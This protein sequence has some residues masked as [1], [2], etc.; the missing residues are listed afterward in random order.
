MIIRRCLLVL[1]LTLILFTSLLLLPAQAAPASPFTYTSPRDGAEVVMPQTTIAV[2][3]GEILAAS[4]LSPDRFHV[5]GSESGSH[6][7]EVRLARDERTAIFQPD[8][9]FA[10]GERV[11]VRVAGGLRTEAGTRLAGGEIAFTVAEELSP[12]GPPRTPQLETAPVMAPLR[13]PSRQRANRVADYLTVPDD[14]PRITVT[15]PASNTGEGYI[16]LTNYIGGI[17]GDTSPSRPYLLILDNSGEPVFYRRMTPGKSYWDFKKQP[18]GV[19]S[20][21]NEY[22][23]W[24]VMDSS[25]QII[26][27]ISAGNGYERADRHDFQLLDNGHALLILYDARP[28]DMSKV[29]PDGREDAW[30]I[31]LVIQ[32]LDQDD[33][34]VFQWRSWDY[35]DVISYTDSTVD[36]TAE[37]I[38]YMHTNAVEMDQDG[39]LLISSRFLDEITKINRNPDDNIVDGTIM[40]RFGGKKNQF[41]VLGDSEPFFDQHDIR[42][43]P[44]GNITLFDNHTGPGSTFSRGLEYRL[45]EESMIAEPV[46]EYR[47]DSVSWAMGNTQRLPNG[48]TLLGWG[49]RYP[50]LTEVTPA[51]EKAFELT[52]ASPATPGYAQVSYRAYRFPW[53]GDPPYPPLLLS[54]YAGGKI[55]LYTSWNGATGI[56]AYEIYGSNDV[57][58]WTLLRTEAKQGF[59]SQFELTGSDAGYCYYRV[60]PLD[61]AFGET[62]FSNLQ[63]AE[64]CVAS[65]TLLPWVGYRR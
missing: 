58:E 42:R 63:I 28:V 59:E 20:Y 21:G 39:N 55:T 18:S 30:V 13:P 49:L 62:Q 23:S 8:Q 14:Y 22:T 32:E 50:T 7:G 54:R 53:E 61:E 31:G 36:L 60:M 41:T 5:A 33:N 4:S 65:I 17:G 9:P 51:G 19:L 27:H 3:F 35:T 6:G 2:R 16:F 15:V 29:V 10:P 48:N 40:W 1:L 46:W 38:D 25:Y 43:L 56:S 12:S 64:P 24:W 37:G 44:G 34:V 57:Q 11:T 47:A 26:D 52:L 45:D